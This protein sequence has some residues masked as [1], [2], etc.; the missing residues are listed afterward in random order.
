VPRV[1][2]RTRSTYLFLVIPSLCGIGCSDKSPPGGGATSEDG[3][4]IGD[5]A[6]DVAAASDGATPAEDSGSSGDAA[7]VSS[8]LS[9]PECNSVVPSGPLVVSTSSS[10]TA[11]TAGGGSLTDGT[12]VLE[13]STYYGGS[14]ASETFQT[15]WV[16]CGS[17]W[18]VAENFIT[19]DGGESS[20]AVN[21]L[22]TVQ[23][24]SVTLNPT[25]SSIAGN[26]TAMTRSFTVSGDQLTF[27]QSISGLTLV[28][29]YVRQ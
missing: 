22:A 28:G 7:C 9:A 20:L 26:D 11:P 16:I 25:C 18:D 17:H 13:S 10:A 19:A 27:I 6:A 2:G 23:G 5:A 29:S 15:T 8:E 24:S 14:Q 3:G 12:Y 4:N 1:M 21:Y